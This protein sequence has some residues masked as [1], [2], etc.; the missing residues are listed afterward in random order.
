MKL[1]IDCMA[2]RE[3][4]HYSACAATD[5]LVIRR[6]CELQLGLKVAEALRRHLVQ[7][8]VKLWLMNVMR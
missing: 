3:A 8:I 1:L 2:V 4:V 6:L 5:W 7:Y